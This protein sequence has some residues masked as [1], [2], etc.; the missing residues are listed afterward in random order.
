MS[1]EQTIAKEFIT[2][3]DIDSGLYYVNAAVTT[4]SLKESVR[5]KSAEDAFAWI[6]IND[7]KNIVVEDIFYYESFVPIR[8]VKKVFLE[9]EKEI[10]EEKFKND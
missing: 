3:K 4:N 7:L 1:E 9:T 5:F 8:E 10:P 2:V 6:E